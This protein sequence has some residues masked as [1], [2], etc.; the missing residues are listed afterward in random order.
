M[1]P[2]Y[3]FSVWLDNEFLKF[4]E[5]STDDWKYNEYIL[6]YIGKRIHLCL[7]AK[8][9]FWNWDRL[10]YSIDYCHD[11]WSFECSL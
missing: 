2:L 9:T 6:Q 4:F 7:T 5:P 11:H 8:V 3:E 1:I 10:A